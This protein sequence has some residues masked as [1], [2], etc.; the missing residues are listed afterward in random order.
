MLELTLGSV[1]EEIVEAA[2]IHRV[3]HEISEH[4]DSEEPT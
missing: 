4:R 1:P 3:E 2:G